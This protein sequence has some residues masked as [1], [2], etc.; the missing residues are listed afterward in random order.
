MGIIGGHL[1]YSLLRA[2]SF[3]RSYHSEFTSNAQSKEPQ[4]SLIDSFG[5]D[6]YNLIDNKIIIDF[7][8]GNGYQSI[9]MA[10]NGALS[11][12]GIDIQ[13]R[14]LSKAR[15]LAKKNSVSNKCKFT[16]QTE[17]KADIIICKDAFEHFNNPLET[18]HVMKT[19][20][21][22]AGYILASFGPPWL[23]P[24]GGHLFSVF[25]WAHLLF[26]EKALVRWRSDFKS[27]DVSKI[28]DVEGGLNKITIK[29]FEQI[30]TMS[31][32]KFAEIEIVPI[33]G[34]SFLKLYIVREFGS[35]L[36]RCKL[37]LKSY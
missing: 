16:T 24:H 36:I 31:P 9:E 6:F 34:I 11:V 19:L 28:S 29:K 3:W 37:I 27:D 18:L 1:G 35:S 23:H 4:T 2:Y 26:T 15:A 30:V 8:C 17:E 14:F 25:P 32:F 20:L 10:L 12:I 22:P 5:K 33:K 13:E 7:G 21:K